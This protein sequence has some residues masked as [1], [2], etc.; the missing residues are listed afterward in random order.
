VLLS[1]LCLATLAGVAA[2]ATTSDRFVV[3]QVIVRGTRLTDRTQVQETLQDLVVGRNLW[4]VNAQ[5]AVRALRSFPTV[6]GVAV[7]R[8]W[9]DGL[10][11][12]IREREPVAVVEAEG[13]RWLVD[14][15]SMV[16]APARQGESYPLL[17]CASLPQGRVCPGERLP[18]EHLR[19]ALAAAACA[20]ALELWPLQRL[21]V[22]PQGGITCLSKEG[23]E[24]RCGA[25][26]RLDTKLRLAS[27]V[28]ASRRGQP[29]AV[30]DVADPGNPFLREGA[31]TP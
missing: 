19:Q 16:L 13:E 17:S 4:L 28:L 30:V 1:F 9:P 31:A 24:I 20:R 6:A 10:L 29:V 27:A 2:W 5:T 7:Q 21:E 23:V 18:G 12:L 25:P 15:E 8:R 14:P 3:K 11:V 22:D 26:A